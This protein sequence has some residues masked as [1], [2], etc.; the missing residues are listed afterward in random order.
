MPLRVPGGDADVYFINRVR[1]ALRDQP[2]WF[3]DPFTTDGVKGSVTVAGSSPFRLKRAPVVSG[4][5]TMTVAAGA[6]VAVYD[7]APTGTQVAIVT[8]TGEFYFVAP[9][10]GAQSILSSYQATRYSDTQI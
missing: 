3:Q 7:V 2:V 8:D 10:A 6:R 5:V 4:S 9:P 1:R